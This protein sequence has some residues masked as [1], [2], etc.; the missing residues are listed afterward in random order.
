M[1]TYLPP[2][3]MINLHEESVSGNNGTQNILPLDLTDN[4]A[5]G[6]SKD[7]LKFNA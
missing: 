5:F 7:N 3:L 2:A 4:I 1:Y 6:G